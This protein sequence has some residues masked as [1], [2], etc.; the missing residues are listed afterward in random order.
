MAA[1]LAAQM[2][3]TRDA[4]ARRLDASIHEV[5]GDPG[6]LR[7]AKDALTSA[8]T[9]S[10]S[11]GEQATQQASSANK[12][13]QG[14]AYGQMQARVQAT[15][16]EYTDAGAV[17]TKAADGLERAATALEKASGDIGKLKQTFT[18]AAASLIQQANQLPQAQE[19]S[20]GRVLAQ[21]LEKAGK[22]AIAKTDRTLKTFDGEMES[23]GSS[24]RPGKTAKVGR[25][26]GT[27]YVVYPNG[28]ARVGGDRAWRNNNPGNIGYGPRAARNG[29][30]GVDGIN[31][32]ADGAFAVFPT[33][34]AGEAAMRDV[35]LSKYG[36]MTFAQALPKYAPP[37][38]NDVAGYL[39]A[40]Q[41]NSG[42]DVTT[43]TIN[44]YSPAEFDR[45]ISAMGRHESARAG[46]IYTR[47][48]AP[49]WLLPLLGP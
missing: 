25:A 9:Q 33:R 22:Q 30:I 29:A 16:A 47:E 26:N 5:T 20:A 23:I 6:A 21:N 17:L 1:A 32:P 36:D 12:G 45:L 42:L 37:H 28:E 27:G 15:A 46:T 34:E 19:A 39:R 14:G 10:N 40:V 4:Y 49:A 35:M 3:A 7:K 38:E 44:S 18:E 24:V 13:W 43:R 8:A 11:T 48:T 31:R 2:T 41:Q